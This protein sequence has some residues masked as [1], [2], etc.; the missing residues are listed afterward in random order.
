M[1]HALCSLQFRV[2]NNSR[3]FVV[4]CLTSGLFYYEY[5]FNYE[6][7]CKGEEEDILFGRCVTTGSS[8]PSN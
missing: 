3:Q 8:P 5:I 4:S 7:K 6:I 1:S 2:H